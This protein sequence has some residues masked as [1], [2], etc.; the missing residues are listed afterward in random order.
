MSNHQDKKPKIVYVQPEYSFTEGCACP[1]CGKQMEQAVFYV[2]EVAG[3]TSFQR[4]GAGAR[5]ETVTTTRYQNVRPK[6]GGFCVDCYKRD[7]KADIIFEAV[8]AGVLLAVTV[9]CVI[10]GGPAIIVAL[11]SGFYCL[12]WSIALL[13]DILRYRDLDGKTNKSK[14]D[15]TLSL[16]F[17]NAFKESKERL[18]KANETIMSSSTYRDLKKQNG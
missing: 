9:L 8:L 14:R 7:R 12:R 16:L 17:V 6:F 5:K 13:A 2:G 3:Q 4:W 15:D 18:C 1:T 11:I 10:K